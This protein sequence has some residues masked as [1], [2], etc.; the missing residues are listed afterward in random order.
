MLA[1]ISVNCLSNNRNIPKNNQPSR[2]GTSSLKTHSSVKDENLFNVPSQVSKKYPSNKR[3]VSFSQP[4]ETQAE[5][6]KTKRS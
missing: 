6:E 5:A 1:N 4:M 3:D 2:P